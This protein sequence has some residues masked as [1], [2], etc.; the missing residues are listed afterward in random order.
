[1][2][3]FEKLKQIA[4]DKNESDARKKELAIHSMKQVLLKRVK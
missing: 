3:F 1:M 2:G 4:S